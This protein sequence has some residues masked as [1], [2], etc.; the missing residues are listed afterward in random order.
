MLH[1]CSSD[2][3]R[4]IVDTAKQEGCDL[5]VV[6]SHCQRGLTGTVLGSET[7]KVLS[8][9]SIPCTRVPQQQM[10]GGVRPRAAASPPR[11]PVCLA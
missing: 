10:M 8:H 6:G 4:A 3:Y 2:P 7:V 5:I 11:K 9:T 1:R